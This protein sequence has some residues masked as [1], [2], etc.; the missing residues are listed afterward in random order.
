[1]TV[2]NSVILVTKLNLVSTHWAIRTNTDC[3]NTENHLVYRAQHSW[4]LSTFISENR[5]PSSF[6]SLFPFLSF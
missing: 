1:V 4:C 2:K 6:W 5:R 3:P